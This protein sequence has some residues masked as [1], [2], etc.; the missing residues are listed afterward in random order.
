[1]DVTCGKSK[2]VITC[3][4]C[5]PANFAC[6][7]SCQEFNLTKFQSSSTTNKHCTYLVQSKLKK[8]QTKKQRDVCYFSAGE[9]FITGLFRGGQAQRDAAGEGWNENEAFIS[10]LFHE[11]N[12][13]VS[14]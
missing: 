2:Q 3:G 13:T 4:K 6:W 14:L 11:G 5:K 9:F 12:T 10:K 1:M 7:V 8:E